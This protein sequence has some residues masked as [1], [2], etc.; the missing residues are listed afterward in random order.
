ME[1]VD[2]RVHAVIAMLRL[3]NSE[4]SICYV[5]KQVAVFRMKHAS[6]KRLA[7]VSKRPNAVSK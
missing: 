2:V 7:V 5:R 6:F 4:L 3:C 1:I